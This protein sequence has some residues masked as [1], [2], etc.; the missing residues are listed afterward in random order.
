MVGLV[1]RLRW[2]GPGVYDVV[3]MGPGKDE[4]GG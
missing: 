3:G 1:S 2:G 4:G